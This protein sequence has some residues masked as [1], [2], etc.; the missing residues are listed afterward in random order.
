MT[1]DCRLATYQS[2]EVLFCQSLPDIWIE[3]CWNLLWQK[4]ILKIL[5]SW[6]AVCTIGAMSWSWDHP[7][8]LDDERLSIGNLSVRRP[9]P[10][11]S[12]PPT[13][14]ARLHSSWNWRDKYAD[15]GAGGKRQNS[16]SGANPRPIRVNFC[17][18]AAEVKWSEGQKEGAKTGRSLLM[19]K[20]DRAKTSRETD[21][22]CAHSVHK[23]AENFFCFNCR[24]YLKLSSL[25]LC[26]S[27]SEKIDLCHSSS[28][29]MY[30]T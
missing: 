12:K 9:P 10:L 20:R 6:L 1:S 26:S 2:R 7:V 18:S 11:L 27:F 30:V 17:H 24:K 16:R 29:G 8:A 13:T 19:R 21:L 23:W 28:K 25:C 3:G 15:K 22:L 5:S 4:M 14:M